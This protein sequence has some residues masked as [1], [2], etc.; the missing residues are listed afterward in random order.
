MIATAQP[1]VRV[2]PQKV[3]RPW[4]RFHLRTALVA[5]ICISGA[6]SMNI[7]PRREVVGRAV[8]DT[9][10]LDAPLTASV[11]GWPW[12]YVADPHSFKM[13]RGQ[14]MALPPEN[15]SYE[16]LPSILDKPAAL[17]RDGA[18]AAAVLLAVVI[19]SEWSLRRKRATGLRCDV[20]VRH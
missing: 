9:A 8:S 10:K 4:L 19:L 5:T 6:M 16:L 14:T 12:R 1:R 3:R 15:L 17:K 7:K 11:N 18:L 2:Q 13:S 20:L